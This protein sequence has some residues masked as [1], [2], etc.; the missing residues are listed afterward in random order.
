MRLPASHG[1]AGKARSHRGP[2]QGAASGAVTADIRE[3]LKDP[4][5][6]GPLIVP[7]NA[8]RECRYGH[9][10][11]SV[12]VDLSA[13]HRGTGVAA[14]EWWKDEARLLYVGVGASDATVL[15]TVQEADRAAIDCPLGWPDPLVDFLIAHRAGRAPAP[16]GLSGLEWR[17]TLT[18]RATDLHVAQ[19]LPGAVPLAVGADR[20]AAVAMRAAGLLAALADLGKPV[21]RTGAGLLVEVYPAAALRVWVSRAVPTRAASIARH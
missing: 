19:V 13:E 12:G 21:D 16:S 9:C 17:R 6:D 20:I 2:A 14:I 4:A 11:R 7:A 5:E 8:L 10:V 3:N 18:R 1:S 15:Q